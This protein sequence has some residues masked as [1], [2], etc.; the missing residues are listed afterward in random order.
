MLCTPAG[1]SSFEICLLNDTGIRVSTLSQLIRWSALDAVPSFMA[2]Q[3]NEVPIG[4][5]N[6]WADEAT[7][8]RFL[9]N[10]HGNSLRRSTYAAPILA[11]A[12]IC[13][14]LPKEGQEAQRIRLMPCWRP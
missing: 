12:G 10:R 11:A 4:A 9:Q 3:G 2:R 13:R 14:I 6:D 7:L 1:R 8:E 5:L